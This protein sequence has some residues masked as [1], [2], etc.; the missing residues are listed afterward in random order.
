M[1]RRTLVVESISIGDLTARCT[2]A[3]REEIIHLVNAGWTITADTLPA[4]ADESPDRAVVT[5]WLVPPAPAVNPH[6]AADATAYTGDP[7]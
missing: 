6:A 5:L 3:R 4:L 1:T 7:L 2:P